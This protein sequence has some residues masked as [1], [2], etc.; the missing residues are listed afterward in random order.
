[1]VLSISVQ[2]SKCSYTATVPGSSIGHSGPGYM[3][4]SK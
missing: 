3:V 2:S 1:M 4:E